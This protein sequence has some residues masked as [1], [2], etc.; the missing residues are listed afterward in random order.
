LDRVWLIEA[1][2]EQVLD[3]DDAEEAGHPHTL[4]AVQRRRLGQPEGGSG[5]FDAFTRR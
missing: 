1:V 3:H 5:A 4:E 2:A